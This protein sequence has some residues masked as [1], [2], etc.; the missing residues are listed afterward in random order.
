MRYT[1]SS[2]STTSRDASHS[3]TGRIEQASIPFRNTAI[4]FSECR[5][6]YE[7]NRIFALVPGN[8]HASGSFEC[9]VGI[10]H[11]RCT[12]KRHARASPCMQRGET[13]MIQ[14]CLFW[15]ESPRVHAHRSALR[16]GRVHSRCEPPSGI[17]CWTG[18]HYHGIPCATFLVYRDTENPRLPQQTTRMVC[19]TEQEAIVGFHPASV[20]ESRASAGSKAAA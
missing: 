13:R 7:S 12:P 19:M 10:L 20:D 11:R 6:V 8:A 2:T 14:I 15:D 1:S 18:I 5:N 9:D 17:G 16:S 3:Y 4:K